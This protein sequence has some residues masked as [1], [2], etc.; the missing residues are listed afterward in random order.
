MQPRGCTLVIC[1][2]NN[3]RCP[4][5]SGQHRRCFQAYV[6]DFQ[7][8]P[9]TTV[10]TVS[11]NHEQESRQIQCRPIRTLYE[12]VPES[13][14]FSPLCAAGM[15]QQQRIIFSENSTK[16]ERKMGSGMHRSRLCF[17][18]GAL[19]ACRAC[20]Y[21]N[22][23]GKPP[24]FRWRQRGLSIGSWH[25]QTDSA[26][27]VLREALHPVVLGDRRLLAYLRPC[28]PAKRREQY[29]YHRFQGP[30]QPLWCRRHSPAASEASPGH[31]HCPSPVCHPVAC[32][33]GQSH[34][35]S[36]SSQVHHQASLHQGKEQRSRFLQ[37][38]LVSLLLLFQS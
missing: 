1:D 26:P 34:S 35:P 2:T 25:S 29:P 21:R 38:V 23:T 20:D 36:C 17:R 3:P 5:R 28:S 33:P 12:Q 9:Y 16:R 15:R 27:T 8:I 4:I 32:H 18:S 24:A 13:G 37:Q 30:V 14:M 10:V 22:R 19:P 31:V 7:T 11:P 6:Q